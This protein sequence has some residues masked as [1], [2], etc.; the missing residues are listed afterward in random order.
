LFD[1]VCEADHFGALLCDTELLVALLKK[2]DIMTK[3]ETLTALEIAKIA[4]NIENDGSDFY[5][6]PL[7]RAKL[8][9]SYRGCRLSQCCETIFEERS[10][11]NPHA[12]FC[13][14]RRRATVSGDPVAKT[15]LLPSQ[16]NV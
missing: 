13:G 3:K 5:E 11:E 6:Y 2:E 7:L 9:L 4:C 15:V 8:F 12:T 1:L 16:L 14:S 10:A